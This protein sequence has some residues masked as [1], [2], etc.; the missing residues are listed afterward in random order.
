MTHSKAALNV[1][2]LQDKE[3]PPRHDCAP[4]SLRSPC[5]CQPVMTRLCRP[6]QPYHVCFDRLAAA[7]ACVACLR[8]VVRSPPL[9]HAQ[10]P[11]ASPARVFKG[12]RGLSENTCR[13]QMVHIMVSCHSF[14]ITP[15]QLSPTM[16]ILQDYRMDVVQEEVSWIIGLRPWFRFTS[17]RFE[18]APT[19]YSMTMHQ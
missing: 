6:V 17:R 16:T 7:R 11:A 5:V 18:D 4:S 19:S 10:L 9:R 3:T 14:S 8:C 1:S 2:V 13:Q 15:A 12:C